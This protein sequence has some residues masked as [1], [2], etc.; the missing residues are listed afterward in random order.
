M[1]TMNVP[2]LA[3]ADHIFHAAKAM[4][5]QRHISARMSPLL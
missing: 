3:L 2:D 5:L 1:V 4:R